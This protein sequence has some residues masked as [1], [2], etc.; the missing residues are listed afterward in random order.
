[1][2]QKYPV[3]EP[4]V[5]DAGMLLVVGVQSPERGAR[6]GDTVYPADPDTELGIQ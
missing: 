5:N 2:Q 1:M 3:G 6:S 4:L